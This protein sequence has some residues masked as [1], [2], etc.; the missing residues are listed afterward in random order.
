MKGLLKLGINYKDSCN[1]VI[2]EFN[3]NIFIPN[4][5]KIS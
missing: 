5:L 3:K 4:Y 2:N 1:T